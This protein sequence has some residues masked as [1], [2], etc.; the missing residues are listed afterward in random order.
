M[1]VARTGFFTHWRKIPKKRKTTRD[2]SKRTST[3][4]YYVQDGHGMKVRVCKTLFLS[5]SGFAQKNDR[6]VTTAMQTPRDA[7]YAIDTQRGKHPP[8]NKKRHS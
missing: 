2:N 7:A 4:K 8:A 5:T 3:I 6:F 1:S